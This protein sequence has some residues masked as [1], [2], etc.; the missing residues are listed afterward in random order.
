MNFLQTISDRLRLVALAIAMLSLRSSSAAEFDQQR[1]ATIPQRMQ[2]FV[3]EPG[4]QHV[5]GMVVVVGSSQGI[6]FHE[7]LGQQSLET[8]RPMSKD[9]LFRIASMTKP[10]TAVAIMMLEQEG[11]LSVDDPVEKHLPEFKGQLLVEKREG[12]QVILK[13]PSRPITI[14][15][16]LTHTSGMPGGYPPGVSDMY[17]QRDY[18]LAEAVAMVSQRPLDFEPGSKWSYCNTGIDTLGRIIEVCS[19]QSYEAFLQKRIFVPLGMKDTTFHP[20]EEQL[21]R[22]A[23]LYAVKDDKLAAAGWVLIGDPRDARHP[24]PAGGLFS[25]GSDLAKLYQVMLRGGTLGNVRFVSEKGMKDMTKLQTG[26]LQCGFTP[27]MGFGFGWAVVKEPQG[28]HAMMSPGTYGHG[29]AFG[30]QGWLD[31]QQDLFAILLIQRTGMP[32]SDASDLRK[33]LQAAA[34]EALKK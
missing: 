18:S 28:V 34:V 13:K 25:T 10:I 24:I 33:E 15:D 20:S 9:A 29:G 6:A 12:E 23:E 21:K 31:P 1:L 16:L 3:E 14:R 30:T 2:K 17:F 27:G 32:N 19:G 4:A 26:D 11:A 7:A 5:A 22:L 8:K